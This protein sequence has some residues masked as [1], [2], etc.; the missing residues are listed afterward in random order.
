MKTLSVR[1]PWADLI[2]R[3][4]KDIENRTWTTAYR[5][6]LLIHAS[7]TLVNTVALERFY[8]EEHEW[9][10]GGFVGIVDLVDVVT[11]SK[12]PWA[13]NDGEAYHWVLANPRR[14]PFVPMNG[15]LNLYETPWPSVT[16]PGRVH[17]RDEREATAATRALAAS[18][19][20]A[21]EVVARALSR[22]RFFAIANELLEDLST[23]HEQAITEFVDELRGGFGDVLDVMTI[24]DMNVVLAH[25]G[26]QQRTDIDSAIAA[27]AYAIATA[28]D[29]AD[30]DFDDED[31][32]ASEDDAGDAEPETDEADDASLPAS[33]AR[34]SSP[35]K[36]PAPADVSSIDI[37]DVMA[38]FRQ[39]ARGQG[40]MERLDLLRG[41]SRVLGYARLGSTIEE[42]LRGHL[43]A[44]VRRRVIE[45]DGELV[46][47]ATTTIDDYSMEELRDALV[48][49][50]RRG[51]RVEREEAMRQT[52]N[53]LGFRRVTDNVRAAFKSAFNSAIRQGLLESEGAD[54]VVRR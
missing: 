35:I 45:A 10:L 42:V 49:G 17:R 32:E 46:R 51:Q 30:D 43:R 37:D 48:M 53:G 15:K 24:D 31:V 6:P 14:V 36:K 23:E 4:I 11:D 33:G 19:V 8:G 22:E 39:A 41:V 27:L 9:E 26:Q 47:A 25:V 21:V 34:T 5:G 1:Q 3:G 7:K 16:A 44:A 20:P 12:S 52:V 54:V 28:D 29:L 2:I 13:H 18:T 38:A 50:L 40:S